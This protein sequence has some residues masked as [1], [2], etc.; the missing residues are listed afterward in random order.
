MMEYF[1]ASG[2]HPPLEASLSRR[3]RSGPA[4]RR[5]RRR[6]L[7]GCRRTKAKTW[8]KS[9]TW[10]SASRRPRKRRKSSPFWSTNKSGLGAQLETLRCGGGPSGSGAHGVVD[11]P[12]AGPDR[13]PTGRA[14]R[15]SRKRSGRGFAEFRLG[16]RSVAHF[17]SGFGTKPAF[18]RWEARDAAAFCTEFRGIP[19]RRTCRSRRA[20]QQLAAEAAESSWRE[21]ALL[22]LRRSRPFCAAFF[23]KC[24]PAESPKITPT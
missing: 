1:V 16:L 20:R 10:L 15:R 21:V 8:P 4:G 13:R 23:R 14:G 3:F 18:W 11:A 7:G 17:W 2:E 24:S 6:R 9:I 12:A 22:S 5:R 19:G